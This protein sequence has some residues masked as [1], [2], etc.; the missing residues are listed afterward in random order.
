MFGV[1]AVSACRARCRPGAVLEN[2]VCR[3]ST[4]QVVGEAEDSSGGVSGAG[5]MPAN[6]A[7]LGGTQTGTLPDP[8]AQPDNEGAAHGGAVRVGDAAVPD[9]S[10]VVDAGAGGSSPMNAGPAID[11]ASTGM[12]PDGRQPIEETCNSEDDDCDGLVDESLTM[13][14]GSSA[15]VPCQLGAATCNAGQWGECIGAVEPTPEVCDADGVDENCDGT[16]NE[17][18]DCVPGETMECGV[19]RGACR[20]GAQ[21]CT[22]EG[23]FAATCEGEIGPKSEECEGRTDDDCDGLS[24]SDDPDCECINGRTQECEATGIGVCSEGEQ[25]CSNGKWGRCVAER[26][27]CVCDDSQAPRDCGQS[28]RGAC[29][30]GKERCVQGQWT[31]CEGEVNPA[32]ERCD[33]VDSDCDGLSDAQDDDAHESCSGGGTCNGRTCETPPPPTTSS[34]YRECVTEA[35]CDANS[36]CSNASYPQF[37]AP[38]PTGGK[39]PEVSGYPTVVFFETGCVIAC[40]NFVCPS[41]LPSCIGN[42]FTGAEPASFCVPL[43]MERPR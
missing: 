30:L 40:P 13:E 21:M 3:S 39:C 19:T 1:L 17:G 16:A 8:A 9:P 26:R 22:T 5:A 27:G 11:P 33:G 15:R 42:P 24:D 14:C 36:I 32:P 34:P 41:Y 37:C 2:G 35:D 28:S 38:R 4:Q 43:P 10:A 7:G 25:T 12:C 18:C 31:S 23:K 6:S 29:R 20:A